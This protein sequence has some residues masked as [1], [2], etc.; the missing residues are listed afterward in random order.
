MPFSRHEIGVCPG[1][2]LQLYFP[3]RYNEFLK[4][5]EKRGV[6]FCDST[7]MA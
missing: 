5:D 7:C 2:D 4:E 3:L 6:A 1:S